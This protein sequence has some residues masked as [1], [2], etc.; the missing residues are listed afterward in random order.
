MVWG[1]DVKSECVEWYFKLGESP[2]SV[3][4]KYMAVYHPRSPRTPCP[5]ADSIKRWVIEFRSRRHC[6]R[7]EKVKTNFVATPEVVA[8]IGDAIADNPR[9]SVRE[10]SRFEGI[11]SKSTCSRKLREDGY[12]PYKLQKVQEILPRHIV[13]RLSHS[14]VMLE[15]LQNNEAFLEEL[16][17]SDESTF[18]IHGRL[19]CQNSRWW[20]KEN[21]HWCVS[22]PLHSPKTNVWAAIGW[23]GV[24]GP[25]FID[26]NING[27]R[28]LEL[29]EQ[30]VL[31]QLL[32]WPNSATLVYMHDG[33]P[34]HHSLVV[35]EFLNTHLP[36]RWMGRDSRGAPPPFVWPAN[37]PDLT[38]MDFF[39]WGYVKAK[40][41]SVQVAS[42]RELKQKVRDVVAEI[43]VEMCRAALRNYPKRLRRCLDVG[44]Q[45]VERSYPATNDEQSH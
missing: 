15:Q 21:L 23:N 17:F 6:L 36:G 14:N 3:R 10:L 13:Q 42:L 35:R 44:G 11:P 32:Q 1:A 45:S 41:Y 12:H 7:K 28:Y 43:S 40:V 4:R 2:E 39:L 34:P 27:A 31:P 20:A 33:A 30:D 25:F 18:H 8:R 16:V 22:E 29:L 26:E 9:I 38:P 19:N 37:S 24:V 5:S